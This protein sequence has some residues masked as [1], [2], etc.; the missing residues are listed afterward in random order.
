TRK[1]LKKNIDLAKEIAELRSINNLNEYFYKLKKINKKSIVGII[2]IKDEGS[3]QYIKYKEA[4]EKFSLL[5][6]KGKLW[7]SYL[8]IFRSNGE[9]I[10]EKLED[11]L[12]TQKIN[13]EDINLELVSSGFHNG[14]TSKIIV[15]REEYSKNKRGLNIVIL[16][17]DNNLVIDTF[18]V[19]TFEDPNLIINR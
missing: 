9:V 19:D 2:S 11:C 10:Y 18:N 7:N 4:F 15:N 12:L 14:N 13:L 5:S 17:L 16:D 3:N 8:S 1:E 6:L